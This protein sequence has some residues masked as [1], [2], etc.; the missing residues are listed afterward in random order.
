MI[1]SSGCET[2]Q[3]I[4]DMIKET[5]SKVDI[6]EVDEDGGKERVEALIEHGLELTGK[7]TP[8]FYFRFADSKMFAAADAKMFHDLLQREAK[9]PR[10]SMED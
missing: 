2:C 6:I 1:S 5:D 8:Q 10:G 3:K 7:E 4:K 9:G